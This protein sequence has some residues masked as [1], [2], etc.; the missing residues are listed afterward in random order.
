MLKIIVLLSYSLLILASCSK[1]E[2]CIEGT[3][4][5]DSCNSDIVLSHHFK[6]DGLVEPGSYEIPLRTTLDCGYSPVNKST[7]EVDLD[8]RTVTF[9]LWL[10][11]DSGVI[12]SR[13]GKVVWH[14]DSLTEDYMRYIAF[15][16]DNDVVFGTYIE[17]WRE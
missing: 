9:E 12:F 13:P 5:R 4:L 3:W 7:Y 11:E 1:H 8:A 17:L 15:D 14:I 16:G 6:D 2:F 10:P